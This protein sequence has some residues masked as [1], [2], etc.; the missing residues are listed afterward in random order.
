MRLRLYTIHHRQSPEEEAGM[1]FIRTSDMHLQMSLEPRVLLPK[2]MYHG[3][4]NDKSGVRRGQT[5]EESA[6]QGQERESEDDRVRVTG[7]KTRLSTISKQATVVAPSRIPNART[8]NL[9]TSKM[10][11]YLSEKRKVF[12]QALKEKDKESANAGE[13]DSCTAE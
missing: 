2:R 5:L 8:A 1:L 3:N 12:E 10:R 9:T 11:S 7:A 4:K 6:D 13:V